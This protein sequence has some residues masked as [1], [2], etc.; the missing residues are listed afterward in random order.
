MSDLI[1][2]STT[3]RFTTSL[4]QNLNAYFIEKTQEKK[5][6]YFFSSKERM[7]STTQ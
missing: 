1:I 2:F 4:Y 6:W 5:T 7:M 3:L